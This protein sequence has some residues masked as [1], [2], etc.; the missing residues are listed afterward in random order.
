MPAT[1]R[2][3][4]TRQPAHQLS[5][6]ST[7][8]VL[9]RWDRHDDI[10]TLYTDEGSALDDLAEYVELSWSNTRGQEGLPDQPPADARQAVAS[11]YG[12]D[13]DDRPDEGYSLYQDDIHGRARTPMRL[14]TDPVLAA[15]TLLRAP[16]AACSRA[17]SSLL[18]YAFATPHRPFKR[19]R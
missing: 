13:R 3:D 18:D 12:P 11:Y 16:F 15:R 7:V 1:D 10:V 14:G 9:R 19:R 2:T 17:W 5:P 4:P 6:V 8:W